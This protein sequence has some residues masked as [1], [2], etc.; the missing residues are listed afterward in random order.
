MYTL[1][2]LAIIVSFGSANIAGFMEG[3]YVEAS[4]DKDAFTK[5]VGAT[6]DVARIR[7]RDISGS[8]KLTLMQTS[9]SNTVLANYALSGENFGIPLPAIQPDVFP[10]M[11]TDLLGSTVLHAP[12]AWI[13]KFTNV[14]YGTDLLGREWIFDCDSLI[15]ELGSA[16]IG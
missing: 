10:F 8:I 9:P 2:P 6:G 5:K 14:T 13:R 3:T 11:I 1:D 15:Y 16:A 4:R 7:Q 12:S